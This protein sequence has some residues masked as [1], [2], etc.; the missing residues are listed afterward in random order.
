MLTV[1]QIKALP[2]GRELDALIWHRVMHPDAVEGVEARCVELGWTA[3]RYSTHIAA[4]WDVLMKV[5]DIGALH[6]CGGF[7]WRCEIHSVSPS[8]VDC[9]GQG[10]TAPLAICRAALLWMAQR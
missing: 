4:A 3:P 7:G 6:N 5:Q 10:D 1:D 9:V 2:A 8:A